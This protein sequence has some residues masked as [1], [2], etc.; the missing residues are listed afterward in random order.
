MDSRRIEAARE[1]IAVTLSR[2]PN[3]VYLPGAENLL[4]GLNGLTR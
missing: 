1:E 2:S 3:V 4:F